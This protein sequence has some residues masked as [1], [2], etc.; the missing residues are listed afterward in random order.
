MTRIQWTSAPGR[1]SE[2][3]ECALRTVAVL[4]RRPYI[5]APRLHPNRPHDAANDRQLNVTRHLMRFHAFGA[6]RVAQRNGLLIIGATIVML[7][8]RP[9][10][11]REAL[12]S[13]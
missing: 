12:A 5:G 4:R 3:S 1:A 10:S 7:I 9:V 8:A 11:A 13:I 6:A 2:S